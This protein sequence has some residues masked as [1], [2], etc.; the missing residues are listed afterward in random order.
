VGG[1]ENR[2]RLYLVGFQHYVIRALQGAGLTDEFAIG[3][4]SAVINILDGD[5]F[6]P[7]NKCP[8]TADTDAKPAAVALGGVKDG[9][10]RQLKNLF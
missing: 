2:E 10:N 3:A 1:Y 7:H 8:A 5:N 9:I 4:P 6:V